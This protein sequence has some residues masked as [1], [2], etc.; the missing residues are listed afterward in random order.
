MDNL[1][2]FL[3]IGAARSGTTALYTYLKQHS[4]IFMSP[5]K[6][7]NFFAFKQEDL[8]FQGPGADYVNNSLVDLAAYQALFEGVTREK[9]IGEASPLYLYSEQAPGRIQNLIPNAKLIAILRNPI[10][11]AF[12][13]YLYARRQ[14]IDPLD[15][16][17]EALL[18]ESKRKSEGWMPMFRYSQFPM[19]GEQLSRYF[20]H[21]DGGQ[22]QVHLYEDFEVDPSK[23]MSNVF[24][25]LEVDAGFGPDMSYRPNT[26]GEPKRKWLQDLVM[27]QRASTRLIGKLM[28]EQLRQR[29]RDAVSQENLDQPEMSENAREY[30][31]GEL[32]DDIGRLQSLID[33][34]LSHWLA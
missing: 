10:E 3:V 21:F 23:V 20:D 15:T 6:E 16:F 18:G 32:G 26:G 8:T 19:Y 17:D 27:K 13:H 33:R 5:L 14:M 28:P 2:N 11:Q 4:E 24:E 29:I 31:Q 12:S 7:T 30:L 34:D 25:F 22:I 9:A 1:P